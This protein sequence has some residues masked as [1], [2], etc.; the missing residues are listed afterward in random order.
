[1]A[2]RTVNKRFMCLSL[3][4]VSSRL[5]LE[6]SVDE[7]FHAD[8][9]ICRHRVVDPRDTGSAHVYLASNES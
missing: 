2:V 6:Q 3:T 8:A 1:M 9:F 7:D 5:S 4:P